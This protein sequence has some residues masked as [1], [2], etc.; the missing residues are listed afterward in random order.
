MLDQPGPQGLHDEIF[1]T[2]GYGISQL[3]GGVNGGGTPHPDRTS[4]GTRKVAHA[5]FLSLSPGWLRL[6]MHEDGQACTGDSGAPSQL[7]DRDLVVAINIGGDAACS[8]MDADVRLDTQSAR[9][10]LGQYVTLP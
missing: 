10:F 3:L 7:G 9:A 6:L 1:T 5:S 8:N 2:V 4:A